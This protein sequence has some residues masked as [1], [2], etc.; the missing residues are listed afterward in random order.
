VVTGP[1]GPSSVT[2]EVYCA[3]RAGMPVEATGSSSPNGADF[4]PSTAVATCPADLTPLSGGFAQPQSGATSFFFITG[5]RRVGD[6]W[7]VSG[8]H[9]GNDPAVPLVA[10]AYCA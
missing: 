9:A 2:S 5:S 6:S 1:A 3:R 4:V 8:L 10:A 7:H